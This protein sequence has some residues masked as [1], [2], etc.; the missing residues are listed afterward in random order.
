M[1]PRSEKFFEESCQRNFWFGRREI[2][3]PIHIGETHA[4]GLCG[5]LRP[6]IGRRDVRRQAA[7][8][9]K[10]RAVVGINPGIIVESFFDL[11]EAVYRCVWGEDRLQ[12]FSF[13]F[14]GARAVRIERF[15]PVRR[16]A[17]LRRARN[18]AHEIDSIDRSGHAV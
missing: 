3:I 2:Q 7:Q 13:T 10:N 17:D 16:Q 14:K 1:S 5:K 15:S 11:R 9:F 18:R 8:S 12:N 4:R 6:N